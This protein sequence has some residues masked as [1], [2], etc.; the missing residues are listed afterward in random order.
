MKPGSIVECINP[1]GW[2]D[3]RTKENRPG[4]QNKEICV[5]SGFNP[6]DPTYIMLE[7]YN[8]LDEDGDMLAYDKKYFRELLPPQKIE[9]E[10]FITQTV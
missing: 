8:I 3:I 6:I 2:M 10:Q 1:A 9:I 5:V 7:E 4:P